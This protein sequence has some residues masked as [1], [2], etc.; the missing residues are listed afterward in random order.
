MKRYILLFLF[1]NVFWSAYT[2]YNMN[3]PVNLGTKSAPFNHTSTYNTSSSSFYNSIERSTNEV[4]YKLT[5][6]KAMQIT[7]SHCNSALNATCIYLL[8]NNFHNL[9]Y[10]DNDDWGTSECGN[11]YMRKLLLPGTYYIASEGYNQNGNITSN[12]TGQEAVNPVSYIN[13]VGTKSA[14]FTYSDTQNTNNSINYYIGYNTRDL[15][16][17][18]TLTKPMEVT[19]SHCGS[20][21]SDTYLHLLDASGTR[22]DYN[23]NYGGTGHCS[24]ANHAYLK[25]QLGIGTYYVVS[26][27][28]TQNG[29]ITTAIQGTII[30]VS[31]WPVINIGSKSAN[32]TYTNV[33]NTDT[34][35]NYYGQ[36]T[37]DVRYK[38]E[39][40]K[41]MDVTIS[42]CGSTLADTYLH[43]LDASGNLIE[44]NDNYTGPGQCSNTNR[45]YLKRELVEGTY[46][47]VSEGKNQNGSVTTAI[48][49]EVPVEAFVVISGGSTG[50]NYIATRTYT[51]ADSSTYLDVFQYFDGLGRPIETVQKQ[52]TPLGKDLYSRIEYDN[53]GRKSKTWLPAPNNKTDASYTGTASSHYSD[54]Y[55]YSE[56]KYESSPLNRVNEQY[57][58]GAA[59]RSGSGHK[60]KTEYLSNKAPANDSTLACPYYYMDAGSYKFYKNGNY[61]AGTLYVTKITDENN[62]VFYEFKDKLGR[63]LLERQIVDGNN[64]DTNYIYNDF[65]NLSFV[66][67][68][69]AS[70][71]LT[72]DRA[73][74]LWGN[75]SHPDLINYAYFYYYDE[76]N[77]LQTR[78]IANRDIENFVYDRADRLAMHQDARG[79]NDRKTWLFYK[80]D[81][82]GRV[83]LSG[84]YH[85][86]DN[87]TSDDNALA[88]SMNQKY[89]I[90]NILS[91]ETIVNNAGQYYYTWN[92]FPALS[93]VEVTQVN[94]YDNYTY[95]RN[96]DSNMDYQAKT[97]YGVNHTS[98]KGLLTGTRTK[99][100]DDSGEIISTY[101]YDAKGNLIQKRSTNHLGGYDKEYYAYN[102]NNLITKKY[103]EHTISGQTTPVKEE[104][105][106][107]YSSALRLTSV[108]Y[109][110]NDE[111]PVTLSE[112]AYNELGQMSQKKTGNNIETATFTYNIRGWQ[113]TQTGARFSENLYYTSNPKGGTT[114][115]GGNIAALTWKSS[116]NTA[117][118]RGYSFG[119]DNLGRLTNAVYGEGTALNS[120]TQR[121][122]ESFTYDKHGNPLTLQRY[123][124]KDDN[125]FG[126]VDDLQMTQYLGNAVRKVVD[127]AVDQLGSDVMEFKDG[128]TQPNEEYIYYSSGALMSDYNRNICMIKYNYLTLPKSVQFRYGHR[129]EYVYDAA[130][131]RHR[132]RHKD[133]NHNLNYGWWS[134]DE[135]TNSDIQFTTTTDYVGN[136]IYKNGDLKMILTEGGY[137]EKVNNVFN[138][139]YYLK[140]HLGN[141]RIVMNSSGTVMQVNNYYP[142]GTSIAENTNPRRTDQGIQ[143]YK[144]NG[145]ELD[146]TNGLN[147]YDYEARSYDPTLMRFTTIDPLAEKYYS[148]S[149]YAY[150]LNNPVKFID[151]DGRN[152][153]TATYR[154]YKAYKAYRAVR[155][156]RVAT[157]TAGATTAAYSFNYFL[158]SEQGEKAMNSLI[159]GLNVTDEATASTPE[160]L[161]NQRNNDR[162][163]KEGLDNDQAQTAK[164]I[165]KNITGGMPDGNPAPKR[166]PNDG[167]KW[168]KAAFKV[169]AVGAT[170]RAGLELTNPDPSKDAAEA[171]QEK[172]QQQQQQQQQQQ[173]N[174]SL[175]EKIKDLFSK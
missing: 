65:G 46:Y 122:N 109:K 105:T 8:D 61:G 126:L 71:A 22:I 24:N 81:A 64:Y 121:Y 148:I 43:L 118:V 164:D 49:I 3:N 19:I 53:F 106:Y 147:F 31:A 1:L 156:A 68:P 130:G 97:N 166:D 146:R 116:P 55:P 138:R 15:I 75:D 58:P 88:F 20:A 14:N 114:Y 160:G 93:T 117:T 86:D 56:I 155:A 48:V 102:F 37:K 74:E 59:W 29:N 13:Y 32:F 85:G 73:Y 40:T 39:L 152:P 98:A 124:L 129:I 11:G 9:A 168:T 87:S 171:H 54:T 158:T 139:Y 63:I 66:L 110:L 6:S 161:N 136:K 149:P 113:E 60:V 153:V 99:L 157:A 12:I 33:Q 133:A 101:Y 38:F 151:P 92:V 150:C 169:V 25:K 77:R 167:G 17:Q 47:V 72:A 57:G 76:R 123:G 107:N 159:N 36:S 100:L 127:S 108:T 94:Y 96:N 154:S 42:H 165:D 140:D 84:I 4:W 89:K 172:A 112:Y 91:V 142:S 10:A 16:Y 132:T 44:S 119:Y 69:I 162:K 7:V 143:P 70:A 173:N 128:Y 30:P 95:A 141:N 137:I 23:D 175:W 2:Q 51:Q 82:L 18:F 27:G 80:Y 50:Q 83:I 135:P 5:L 90:E 79:Q 78:L 170:V 144:Y 41:T 134:M 34:S 45:A 52:F 103:M 111:T 145:K 163:G 35:A 115:Y 131:V 28:K 104:Y 67:P 62:N 21:I 120:N 174:L 26:E 125:S